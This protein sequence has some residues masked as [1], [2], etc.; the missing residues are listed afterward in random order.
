ML[1]NPTGGAAVVLV[2]ALLL[3]AGCS[4]K[5][6]SA[7]A[8][9][10]GGVKVDVGVT[11]KT[12]KLG[13]L[14]DRTGPFAP[15]GKAIEQGRALFWAD[16][17][18]VCGRTV[19]FVTKDHKYTT[20]GGANAYTEVKNDVLALDELLGTPVIYALLKD[21]E[22]DGM[23]TMATSF[24]SDLLA[25]RHIRLVG[26]TYDIEMINAVGYLLKTK[27]VA[28]GDKIGHIYHEGP[29]GGNA[30]AGS[31]AAAAN[32]GLELVEQKVKPTDADLTAQV[33]AFKAAGV[34]AVL[35][36]TSS[37]Q[38][39]NAVGVAEASGFDLPFV[40]SNPAF[41]GALLAGPA[42]AAVEKRLLVVASVAP[43]ASTAPGPTKV[44]EAFK[45]RYPNDPKSLFVMYSYAQ[46]Q[47]M[48][49]A[50]DAACAKGDL[51][52]AGLAAAFQ[53]LSSVQTDGL[54]PALDYSRPGGIPTRQ[55]RVLK[56]NST[57][58]GGLEL[59]DDLGTDPFAATY[60]PATS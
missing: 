12:I 57:V 14:T 42:K 21:I 23:P 1:P 54:V 18:A 44:R 20:T 16:K 39:G 56:P 29:Y 33:T 31:K 24:G 26:A 35:L 34:K 5:A 60:Q 45:A 59:V 43:F 49:A 50:L 10:S 55:T 17:A 47:I 25:N 13:V 27:V 51:T 11:N 8:G 9:S 30:A 19:E 37:A 52:R 15:I 4:T 40:A 46:Q 6:D 48:A 41:S 3:A 2:A 53:S 7:G 22:A 38:A 36:T 28:K 58:E 32:A